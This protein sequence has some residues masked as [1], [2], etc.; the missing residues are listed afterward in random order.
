[1]PENRLLASLGTTVFTHM[2][3]LAAAH[4]AVNLGQ[5]FPDT[6]GP[7]DIIEAAARALL[8]QSN[9][10]PPMRGL[11][12]L[13]AAV[14]AHDRRFYGLDLDPERG[15]L[16]TSG[17]TE[18][19]ASALLAFI[20]PG[21]KVLLFE[22]LY[23]SYLP[24]VRRAG[25]VPVLARL[26]P[27]HWDVPWDSVRQAFAD[28]VRL[29]LLNTPMNPC[30][31]VWCYDELAQLAAM[32]EAVDGRVISDEVYEHLVFDGA[33]HVSLLELPGMATRAVK[34]G[35]AGKSFSLTGWKVGYVSGDPALIDQIAKAHQYLTFTTP[36]ALQAAV[37]Y[38]LGKGEDYY[39]PFVAELAAKRDRLALGLASRGFAPLPCQGTYFLT[40]DYSAW[41][42][43]AD[44]LFAEDLVRARG[45]ATIPL[46]PFYDQPPAAQTLIRFCFIKQ[47]SV[48]DAGLAKLNRG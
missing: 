45:V 4:G 41:S 2:S 14:A 11:P 8:D 12:A 44:T 28:G 17:A 38:A 42:R 40:C 6:D 34:I 3:A 33:R 5:G 16:V 25:G 30:A 1:M 18:A 37:A 32:V 7:H 27:P 48:L 31:K 46:S 9:Q 35:S 39:A 43:A 21:D 13:R 15:V 36:P 29:V 26:T 20:E 10:Y 24:M 22:P 19:L 47:D 23:D